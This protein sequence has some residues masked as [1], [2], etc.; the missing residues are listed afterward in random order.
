MV[1]SDETAPTAWWRRPPAVVAVIVA[2]LGVELVLGWS[3]LAEAVR[4]L[5]TPAWNWVAGAVFAEIASMA[6]YARMQQA[7]LRGAGTKVPVR[8]HVPLW[9]RLGR[10]ARLLVECG[11][12]FARLMRHVREPELRREYRKRLLRLIRSRPNVGLLHYYLVKCAMHYHSVCL[13][14]AMSDSA[15]P[16]NTI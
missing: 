10:G 4:Q 11:V 15:A 2:I 8:R 9:R 16:V 3:S 13:V 6:T 5:R 1:A 14:R 12:L 7:L